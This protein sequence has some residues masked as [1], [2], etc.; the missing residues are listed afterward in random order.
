[1]NMMKMVG[2]R[3]RVLTLLIAGLVAALGLSPGAGA[4]PKQE[5]AATIQTFA[6]YG[7]LL[8]LSSPPVSG[9]SVP[10]TIQ[11]SGRSCCSTVLIRCSR[12]DDPAKFANTFVTVGDDGGFS[13]T[14]WFFDGPGR[15]V[16]DIAAVPRGETV[17]RVTCRLVVDNTLSTIPLAPRQY[18]GYGS[19]LEINSPIASSNRVSDF[20][21]ITGKS[22][23][24]AVWTSI[25]NAKT[26]QRRDHIAETLPNGDF[27]ITIPLDVGEGECRISVAS[28]LIAPGTYNTVAEYLVVV[29]PAPID[30]IEPAYRGGTI[31]ACDRFLIKGVANADGVRVDVERDGKSAA[32]LKRSRA[33]AFGLWIDPPAIGEEC[34]VT[35]SSLHR[36]TNRC[37]PR[38]KYRVVRVPK[39]PLLD[40]SEKRQI[41]WDDAEIRVLAESIASDARDPYDRLRAIHDWIASNLAYDVRAAASGDFGPTDAISVIARGGSVCQGYANVTAALA[42]AAGLRVRVVGGEGIQEGI[43]ESHAW[44]EAEV[45]GR[46]VLLDTTW[47]AG[48]VKDGRFVRMP[49]A[50]WFDSSPEEFSLS[51]SGGLIIP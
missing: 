6:G 7:D 50:I 42:A 11:V 10:G 38:R 30:M 49:A 28:R 15:Y 48:H 3:R 29:D 23:F 44:N 20:V 16:M 22:A 35:I 25:E 8:T 14:V 27:A 19:D 39:I 2:A 17:F 47:D 40:D 51:H 12:Q 13:A 1:M 5:E 45:N 32:S 18:S 43:R 9:I 24:P 4:A 37:V 21:T 46:I 33:G 31:L 26:G 36:D 34:L 41:Q